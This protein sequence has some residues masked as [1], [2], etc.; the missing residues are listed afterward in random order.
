MGA[1]KDASGV[2]VDYFW[3]GKCIFK[4]TNM[5]IE[6]PPFEGVFPIEHWDF[7]A[8]HVSFG[9]GIFKK[10]SVDFHLSW[11]AHVARLCWSETQNPRGV[12]LLMEEILHQL[13]C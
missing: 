12:V 8:G 11:S 5:L 13:L 4:K 1:L 10:T 3:R 9:E 6:N 2:D 7:P